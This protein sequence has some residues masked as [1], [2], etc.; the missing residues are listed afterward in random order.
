MK[1]YI[2][3]L[4]D[5]FI[6]LILGMC[7]MGLGVVYSALSSGREYEGIIMSAALL[8][9]AFLCLFVMK[10]Q[11]GIHIGEHAFKPDIKT[12]A[13]TA[14]AAMFYELTALLTIYR[15]LLSGSEGSGLSP[16]E[17]AEWAAAVIVAPAAEELIFRFSMLS[18]LL[19][20]SKGRFQ[21]AVS[22]MMISL[23]WTIIHLS[24]NLLRLADIFLV[25]IL[26]GIIYLKYKNIFY[27]IFFHASANFAA[28]IPEAFLINNGYILYISLPLCMAGIWFLIFSKGKTSSDDRGKSA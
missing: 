8:A 16:L 24:G 19:G 4:G 11:Y 17:I 21:K 23:L 12:S 15:P 28:G 13:L 3:N 27:C 9:G 14:T 6:I 26:L 22:I 20:K 25:G 10:R 1:E 7:P 18:L 5:V 2:K